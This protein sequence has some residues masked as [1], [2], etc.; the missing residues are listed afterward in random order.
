MSEI[1][2]G[3]CTIKSK[4]VIVGLELLRIWMSFEVVCDH[5]W[6]HRD[7]TNPVGL[8]V[9]T[10]G[11]IAVNV[12]MC[13]SFFLVGR[14]ILERG[15]DY[16]RGRIAR[17]A[18]PN[19]GWLFLYGGLR[20]AIWI[21]KGEPLTNMRRELVVQLLFGHSEYLNAAM[22]FQMSL[23]YITVLFYIMSSIFRENSII[24]LI[25][26]GSI[27]LLCEYTPVHLLWWGLP[28][29]IAIS[30]GRTIEMIP[31][32]V[33]GIITRMFYERKMVMVRI[34]PIVKWG[35][36]FV[37]VFLVLQLPSGDGYLYSGIGKVLVAGLT[38][39]CMASVEIKSEFANRAIQV[40][41]KYSLGIYCSH[42]LV[43]LV[44]RKGIEKLGYGAGRLL[45][46]LIIF[47]LSLGLSVLLGN[48]LGKRLKWMVV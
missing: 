44:Y 35:M 45:D 19:I 46:C 37:L 3:E 16:F 43:G 13:L 4:T 32:A 12:F 17:L 40:V 10:Y 31:V 24:V 39:I 42:N 8:L 9:S 28:K 29:D 36:Y 27:C 6:Q 2:K 41:A 47:L 5:C 23:L 34:H 22:W 48:I 1:L 15:G 21:S 20:S 7:E 14:N 11:G 38:V 25:V 26:L 33:L 18:L 30:F